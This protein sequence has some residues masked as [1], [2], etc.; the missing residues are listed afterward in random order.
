MTT[1]KVV[2]T[3]YVNRKSLKTKT[4]PACDVMK[5]SVT[6]AWATRQFNATL[7]DLASCDMG[8]DKVVSVEW[9]AAYGEA[10][11]FNSI[12]GHMGGVNGRVMSRR[13]IFED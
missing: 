8:R 5:T 4:W 13:G 6:R 11:G 9:R 7:K 10:Q 2:A 3:L 1:C 12:S